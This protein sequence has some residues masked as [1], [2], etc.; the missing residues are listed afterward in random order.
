[1]IEI[2]ERFVK[3]PAKLKKMLAIT[4]NLGDVIIK[5]Q[6]TLHLWYYVS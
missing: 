4:L 6:H 1:M 5:K 2:T 3:L